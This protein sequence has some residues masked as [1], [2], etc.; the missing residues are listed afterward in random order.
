[1]PATERRKDI[2]GPFRKPSYPLQR[3][4]AA[5]LLPSGTES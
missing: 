2:E 3:V 1:M 5:T 4:T